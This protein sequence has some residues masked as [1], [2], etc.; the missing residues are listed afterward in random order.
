[1]DLDKNISQ[2][3][4]DKRMIEWNITQKKI[5]KKDVKKHQES[6][7]DLSSLC[8]PMEGLDSSSH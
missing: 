2:L 4:F 1:M 8:E 5:T 6:L 3:T 7:E